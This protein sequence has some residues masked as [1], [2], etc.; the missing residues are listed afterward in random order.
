MYLEAQRVH[1]FTRS[2][3]EVIS[4]SPDVYSYLSASGSLWLWGE[5]LRPAPEIK[6][7]LFLGFTPMLLGVAGLVLTVAGI[8]H[9][10]AASARENTRW[11]RIG[12][13]ILLLLG[14]V[15]LTSLVVVIGTGGLVTTIAGIPLRA[16]NASRSLLQ[17]VLA[18]GAAALLSKHVRGVVTQAL[19]SPAVCARFS[20]R[21]R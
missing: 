6:G 20:A 13:L 5:L 16:S 17:S 19:R 12:G 7:E 10:S 9:R 14:I 2:I 18:T 8:W 15:Q 4:Y 1:G 11:R 3:G 21:W